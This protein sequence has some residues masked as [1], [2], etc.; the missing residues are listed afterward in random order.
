MARSTH[1]QLNAQISAEAAEWFVELR[2][3]DGSAEDR[4]QFDT[5]VRSSP[6]H[7]RAYLEIAAIWK[8]GKSLPSSD[9]PCLEN[10]ASAAANVIELPV[11]LPEPTSGDA[12]PP[13]DDT[14]VDNTRA[15]K[16]FSL[17]ACLAGM[18]M[19][20]G[21]F[22]WYS[23]SRGQI[24]ETGVG[25]HRSVRLRDGSLVELN[26]R[27]RISVRLLERERRVELQEGQALFQVAG[28]PARPFVVRSDTTLVRAVGTQFDV[29]RKRSATV[30]TV[31]EGRVA[32]T[33]PIRRSGQF[34]L[35]ALVPAETNPQTSVSAPDA[36]SA[37]R[38][39]ALFLDA[40]EQ[41]TVTP[42]AVN[43]PVSTN[44]SVAT[45]WTQGQIVLVATRLQDVAE[46]FNRYSERPLIVEDH[47][48][49]DLRLSGVF[50]TEPTFL[51]KYLRGRPDITVRETPTEIRIVRHD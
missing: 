43:R 15:K 44:V 1:S 14:R 45:A 19:V 40:G 37:V 2:T 11:T 27:S 51:I 18:L 33:S 28:D 49:D 26:S 4:A 36:E 25:E 20:A 47:G 41:L 50:S 38:G 30:V 35:G 32:V 42:R 6:D 29:N 39:T 22:A 16:Y 13:V 8:L 46:E 23:L 9:A 34:E 24:Y 7:L 10:D 12:G 48:A 17:A 3:G 5:W 21:A 31:L